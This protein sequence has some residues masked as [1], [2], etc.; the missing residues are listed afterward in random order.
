[1]TYCLRCEVPPGQ[2]S[3]TDTARRIKRK[4]HYGR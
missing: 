2:R 1:M 3:T 4:I